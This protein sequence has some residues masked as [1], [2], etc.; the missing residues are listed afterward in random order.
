MPIIKVTPEEFLG[1][2]TVIHFGNPM[3]HP[4]KKDAKPSGNDPT[5]REKP[6]RKR[7]PKA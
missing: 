2:N 4:S 6:K 7:K 1:G 3:G 5:A